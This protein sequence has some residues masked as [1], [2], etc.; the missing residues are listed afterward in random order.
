MACGL[1]KWVYKQGLT[2]SV[3]GIQRS[4]L[5]R[6]MTS[7]LHL[8]KIKC[9]WLPCRKWKEIEWAMKQGEI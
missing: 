6:V 4:V 8:K 3:I 7:N 9:K 1:F 5:S 2:L